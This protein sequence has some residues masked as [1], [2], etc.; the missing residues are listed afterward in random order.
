MTTALVL[1]G[2]AQRE[3]VERAAVQPDHV[4]ASLVELPG[5]LCG[6]LR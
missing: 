4:Q 5:L 1:T 2:V 6:G 3:D